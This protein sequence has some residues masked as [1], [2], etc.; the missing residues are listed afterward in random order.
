LDPLADDDDT[1]WNN[2]QSSTIL[3]EKPV[4]Q[5]FVLLENDDLELNAPVQS[6]MNSHKIDKQSKNS[7]YLTRQN[8][9]LKEWEVNNECLTLE[10]Y[11]VSYRV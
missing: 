3:S 11:L 9:L 7:H 4:T 2:K 8:T 1:L 10:S 6:S 5:G